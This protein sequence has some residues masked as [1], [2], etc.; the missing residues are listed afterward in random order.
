M[1]ARDAATG[2]V[3][4]M[5]KSTGNVVTP[6]EVAAK[7]GVDTLRVHVLFMAPFEDDCVWDEDGVSGSRRFLERAWR[8]VRDIA[9]RRPASGSDAE[10]AR[11]RHE[12]IRR[13]ERDIERLSFNTAIAGLMELLNALR[14]RM[15]G[16][17]ATVEMVEATRTFTLLLAPFAPHIA[18][19]LWRM[20][21]GAGS[22]H[23]RP[24]PEGD[25]EAPERDTVTLVVQVDGRVRAR[26][27]ATVDVGEAEAVSLALDGSGIAECLR[28]R[29]VTRTVYVPGR[30]VNLVTAPSA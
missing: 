18:E 1:H 12:T 30:L 16:E 3:S 14:S 20:F 22:V 4:R 15:G 13:V 26:V 6:N 21:D 24:W 25:A 10:L 29:E 11:L 8:L 9:T 2:R 19:E 28:G 7:H 17:G 5:S 23:A 27:E